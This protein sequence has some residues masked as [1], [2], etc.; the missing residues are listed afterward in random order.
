MAIIVIRTFIIY[1]ALLVSMRIMGK[2]QLGELEISELVVAVM[3]ADVAS[4]PLQD[5][6]IPLI[7][8]L[9]PVA[10]LFSFE[11][12]V[13]GASTKSIR[14]RTFVYG[15]PSILVENGRIN[16][17]EMRKN[18]FTIDELYEELRQQGVTDVSTVE[19]AVLETGG[20]LN[21]V[22]FPAH[23][24]PT[25]EQLGI[26]T[27]SVSYPTVIIND[28]RVLTQNLKMMGLDEKWLQKTLRQNGFHHSAEVYLLSVDALGKLYISAME[29]RS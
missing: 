19:R 10:L 1:L 5:I 8:G 20:I 4:M 6:G 15:K 3:A 7:N 27:P 12:L 25:C 13:T 24:P 28:G 23:Q 9:I 11:I 16:Q 22:L 29:G 2:R 17:Q 18:R 26:Q 14:F 21:V